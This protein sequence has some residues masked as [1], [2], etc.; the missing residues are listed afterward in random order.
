MIVPGTL[1]GPYKV[2][3]RIAVGGMGEIYKAV[4]TRLEREVAVKVLPALRSA[5]EEALT[6]FHRE[7]KAL[8]SLSHPNILSIFDVGCEDELYYAVRE[9]LEGETLRARIGRLSFE[10]VVDIGIKAAEGLAAAHS[11]GIVH[12]DV[13][14]DNIFLMSDGG[15][16][17]LDFGLIKIDSS[18]SETEKSRSA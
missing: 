7:T 9:L 3:R 11:K 2:Q 15:V 1:L 10:R 17:I 13:K 6:R 8:A 12:R 14:P 16:K 4:D 18:V 5:D